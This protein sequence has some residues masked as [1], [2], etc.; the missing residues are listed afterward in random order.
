MLTGRDTEVLMD[1]ELKLLVMRVESLK[2]MVHEALKWAD[3]IWSR[4]GVRT[5]FKFKCLEFEHPLFPP[6]FYFL[7]VPL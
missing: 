3:R 5:N 7:L 4:S 1:P 2:G 6:T